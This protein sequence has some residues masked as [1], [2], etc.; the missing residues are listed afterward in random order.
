M[1]I[2]VLTCLL[3]D[4]LDVVVTWY[5]YIYD[6]TPVGFLLL[7]G[8]LCKMSLSVMIGESHRIVT[9]SFFTTHSGLCWY[10]C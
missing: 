10:E 4:L 8:L 3:C 7:S 9:S 2:C 6:D 5:G 1:E